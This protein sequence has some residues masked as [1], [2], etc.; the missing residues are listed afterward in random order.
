MAFTGSL[1][2]AESR[3]TTGTAPLTVVTDDS[4]V[5]DP[6][7]P[8]H[9]V[10]T[11]SATEAK[12]T[13][14]DAQLSL[15]LHLP[16]AALKHIEQEY[17]A[18]AKLRIKILTNV[19]QQDDISHELETA[20]RVERMVYLS[21]VFIPT[22]L[23]RGTEH[24]VTF[25]SFGK[26][27]NKITADERRFPHII[28]YIIPHTA[29]SSEDIAA[30]VLVGKRGEDKLTF[31]IKLPE[32]VPLHPGSQELGLLIT[33]WLSGLAGVKLDMFLIPDYW[34]VCVYY[35]LH[36]AYVNICAFA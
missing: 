9:R 25:G 17:I 19:V 14:A 15:S 1:A 16:A 4:A 23:H 30:D 33:E 12:G 36:L 32:G 24:A 35:S 26:G 6:L 21:P 18:A 29:A 10:L 5:F 8:A 28:F 22:Q 27:P 3:K 11:M 20:P 13:T 34:Y 31:V 2:A 7:V